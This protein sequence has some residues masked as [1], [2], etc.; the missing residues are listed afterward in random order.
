MAPLEILEDFFFVERGFLNANHFAYRSDEP[1]LIDTAYLADFDDTERELVA[2]GIDLSRVRRII[3][4]HS[5]CDHIGGNRIIQER[6]GCEIS[7][8]KIGKHFIDTRD[9]WA[10][11]WKYFCQEADFFDCTTGLEDGDM[12]LI[13]PHEFEIIYTPGHASDGIVLYQP[14]EQIL[15]SSDTLWEEDMAVMNI[16]VEGSRAVFC[17]MESIERLERLPVKMVYPGHGKPF[18]DVT[19]AIDRARK[20]LTGFLKDRRR[21][22]NDLLKKIIVYT[23]MMKREMEEATFYEHLTSTPWFP[24]TVELYFNGDRRGKYEEIMNGFLDRGIVK[25]RDGMVYTTVKP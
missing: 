9:H 5:H 1:V 23:L 4:T 13:G 18:S 17:M 10:T 16:R 7:M 12:V 22:G 19:G 11:W 20:R 3:C 25:R 8:H 14:K 6:S 15:I 21:I 24:E 2:L